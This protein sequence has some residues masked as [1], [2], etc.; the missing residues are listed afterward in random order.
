MEAVKDA[1][2]GVDELEG[3]PHVFLFFTE[4]GDVVVKPMNIPNPI[5]LATM[6]NKGVETVLMNMANMINKKDAGIEIAS[7]IPRD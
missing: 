5:F 3:T 1:R 6:L 7:S 2:S 4:N